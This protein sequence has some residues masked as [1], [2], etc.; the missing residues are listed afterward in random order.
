[1][2]SRLLFIVSH[3]EPRLYHYARAAFADTEAVEVILD[4]RRGERRRTRRPVDVDR[5]RGD[6]RVTDVGQTLRH[7]GWATAWSASPREIAPVSR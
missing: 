1:L 2:V 6:R 3:E 5:R 4:R 7:L